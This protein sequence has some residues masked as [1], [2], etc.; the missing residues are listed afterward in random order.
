[1]R[2]APPLGLGVRLTLPCG[3][4]NA[5]L[6]TKRDDL[7]MRVSDLSKTVTGSLNELNNLAVMT[8]VINK[9]QLEDH[10]EVDQKLT[11][12]MGKLDK[13]FTERL[14][15]LT[16]NVDHDIKRTADE[17]QRLNAKFAKKSEEA[18]EKFGALINSMQLKSNGRMTAV[19][20]RVEGEKE[21]VVGEHN[22]LERKL[23][24]GHESL[25]ERSRRSRS[26]SPSR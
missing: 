17:F 25:D 18:D 24:E 16:S 3:W 2:R 1:M 14:T 20:K 26:A 8:D 7:I 21:R 15:E 6:E 9:K 22:S 13:K 10:A 12:G 11:D 23:K 19:E 4:N 5:G